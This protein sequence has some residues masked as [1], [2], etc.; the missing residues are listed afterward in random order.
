MNDETKKYKKN[1]LKK[2]IDLIISL[3]FSPKEK[4]EKKDTSKSDDIYPM[5]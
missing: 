3:F 1:I 2:I 4:K 5:W